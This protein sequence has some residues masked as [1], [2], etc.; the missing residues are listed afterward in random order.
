MT[1]SATRT[2][3]ASTVTRPR[4]NTTKAVEVPAVEPLQRGDHGAELGDVVLEVPHDLHRQD[5]GE[6]DEGLGDGDQADHAEHRH[7]EVEGDATQHPA[8]VAVEDALDDAGQDEQEQQGGS[9]R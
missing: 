1:S 4:T 2:S 7:R 5:V 8:D 6:P 3:P 9:D